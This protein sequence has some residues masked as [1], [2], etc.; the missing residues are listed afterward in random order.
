MGDQHVRAVPDA[1]SLRRFSRALLDDIDAL[2]RLLREGRLEHG[3]T[4]I[5]LEQELF[6]IDAAGRPAPRSAEVLASLQDPSFTTEI[7]RFNLELNVDPLVFGD[8]ALTA[9]ETTLRDALARARAAAR[10]HG[11]DVLLA[12]ILPSITLADLTRANL[13]PTARYHALDARLVAL[14]GGTIRT[15]IQG[16]DALQV[17]LDTVM[18]EAC[19]TSI[20]VHLQVEPERLATVYNI[21][22]LASAPVLAAAVN[23]PLLL[24]RRLWHETRVPTFE[25]AVDARSPA[26]RARG[27]WQRVHF[28]DDWVHGS[29]VDVYRD[30]VARHQVMLVDDTGESSL[31][32]LARGEV[33]RLR[34]LALHN[35]SLYRWNRLCYG[36]SNG[37][38]HLRIEH[39]PL[40][41]GPT[42]RDEVANVAFFLGL[43][44]GLERAYGDV[45]TRHA[46]SDV[47][48][49]FFAAAHHGLQ[50]ELRWDG[51][52]PVSA[53]RL[54]LDELLPIAAEGLRAAGLGDDEIARSLDVIAERTERGVT[55]AQWTRTAWDALRPIANP[56]SRAQALTRAMRDRQWH[57]EPV[58][59]W[60]GI[61]H[62]EC[63]N[64]TTFAAR[65]QEI[66]STDVFTVHPDDHLDVAA[67]VM[68]W[69]HIRHVP[70]QDD[71]GALVGLLSHRMLLGERDSAAPHEG[72]GRAVRDL[73]QT[74]VHTVSP[75]D[76]CAHA[77][78]CLRE[79]RVGCLPVVLDGSLIG[80]VSER[81]LLPF[82]D[83]WFARETIVAP[84]SPEPGHADPADQSPSTSSSS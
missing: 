76:T 46:F 63:A 60:D 10:L 9:L 27:S 82:A 31:D 61:T 23:S 62:D 35:G 7:G 8:G 59:A 69:K 72:R 55:G 68:H 71:S 30:Q 41:S 74:D 43:V 24:Q 19:N 57:T 17:A 58:T 51:G 33:P 77:V 64:W 20:Q 3:V 29:I 40:P 65:V 4:R 50:A 37:M 47:R 26:D 32:V 78:A 42:I 54:I 16:D 73:M 36:I 28:G 75:T 80:I 44:L 6:L 67:S 52:R 15:A 79:H 84:D 66:M 48:A 25:Q 13:T 5:G 34:A 21:A 12:G 2:D 81:D 83:L 18:L 56:V 53:R 39:R 1:E 14:A 11:A 38:P 70:V 45:R 22:Q 49:N